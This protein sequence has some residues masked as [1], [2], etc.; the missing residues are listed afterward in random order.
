MAPAPLT[1]D[2]MLERCDLAGVARVVSAG[3]ASADSPK[4]AKLAFV[5]IL[6]G[7]PPA[8][9]GL[10]HVRL[11]G[12]GPASW[13]DWWDYPVGAL[14]R[15]HLDWSGPEGVYETAWPGAVSEVEEDVAQVA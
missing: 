1:H 8:E 13:S 5:R 14:V 4:F 10:A 6:K 12:G 15:T 9:G 3:R 7:A 11:R 2:E